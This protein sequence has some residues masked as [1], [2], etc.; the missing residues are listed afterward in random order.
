MVRNIY[1]YFKPMMQ[2]ISNYTGRN[3][4]IKSTG[5][6]GVIK[7]TKTRKNVRGVLTVFF[8]I[9]VEGG[10]DVTCRPDQVDIDQTQP[11]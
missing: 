11:V 3:V 9:Q 8:I 4:S 5:A 7:E 1:T 2:A 10:P 6:E